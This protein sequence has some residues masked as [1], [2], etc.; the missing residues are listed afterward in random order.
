[1]DNK[2]FAII[3]GI[4]GIFCL[5]F[6]VYSS[7]SNAENS[8]SQT[9]SSKVNATSANDSSGILV[10]VPANVEWYDTKIDI[11]PRKSYRIKYSEGS[12]TNQRG[13]SE[14]QA[15][16]KSGD[17][18]NLLLV[19]SAYVCQLVGKLG[20]E[21]FAIGNGY[22]G[23]SISG[24]RLYLSIN[25]RPNTFQDNVGELKVFVTVE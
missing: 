3:A 11:P 24:G 21:K 17:D 7:F 4:A 20:V 9:T 6:G 19:S 23:T 13:T 18:R 2:T 15:L 22:S 1:M 14:T 8:S 10:T 12:W 5:I 16:G 25:D